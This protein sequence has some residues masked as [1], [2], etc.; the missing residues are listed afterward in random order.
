VDP[1]LTKISDVAGIPVTM[2]SMD[3]LRWFSRV[4]DMHIWRLRHEKTDVI[5]KARGANLR[6]GY[7]TKAL[8]VRRPAPPPKKRGRY[9]KLLEP[10]RRKEAIMPIDE[11]LKAL[12]DSWYQNVITPV[13]RISEAEIENASC[14]AGQT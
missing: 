1:V 8:A 6:A 13:S 14:T 4:E 7:G 9:R 5:I 11:R 10:S 2:F 12:Y 3:G